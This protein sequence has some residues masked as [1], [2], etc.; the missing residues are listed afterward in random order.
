[1]GERVGYNKRNFWTI[2]FVSLLEQKGESH[3]ETGEKEGE[4]GI[5]A[6]KEA[7]RRG[8]ADR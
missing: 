1:L 2:I 6:T 7:G 3:G 5:W 8:M 4:S